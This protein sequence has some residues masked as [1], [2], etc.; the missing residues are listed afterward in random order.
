LNDAEYNDF[1][2]GS[3]ISQQ[4]A[5]ET[6]E[7]DFWTDKFKLVR[8]IQSFEEDRRLDNDKDGER[9][10]DEKL[11]KLGVAAPAD[12]DDGASTTAASKT[13]PVGSSMDDDASSVATVTEGLDDVGVCTT[14]H[15]AMALGAET[16]REE[17]TEFQ[18]RAVKEYAKAHALDAAVIP[19][20][21]VCQSSEGVLHWA[22]KDMNTKWT[23]ALAQRF[24]RA[25]KRPKVWLTRKC[26]RAWSKLRRRSSGATGSYRSVGTSP[27]RRRRLSVSTLNQVVMQ[28]ST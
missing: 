28:A 20:S 4:D 6:S 15:G 11:K 24:G 16:G 3:E 13:R 25:L 12:V 17:L 1:V 5:D 9:L 23:G 27:R 19:Y 22:F 26:T 2:D 18:S 21:E 8:S 14:P 10:N 7:Q